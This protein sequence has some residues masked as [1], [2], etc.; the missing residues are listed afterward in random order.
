MVLL[1]DDGLRLALPSTSPALVAYHLQVAWKRKLGQ[2]A[3]RGLGFSG[4][5][6]DPTAF[7]KIQKGSR[8]GQAF[9]LLRAFVTQG[10]WSTNRLCAVGYD[11]D[12]SCP[13]CGCE[14]DTLH[15]K[16]FEC[17]ATETLREAYFQAD[18]LRRVLDSE[19]APV[20]LQGFQLLPQRLHQ[21]PAGLGHEQYESWTLTGEPLESVLRGEVFTDGSC[22]KEGPVTWHRTGWAVCKIDERGQLLAWARGVVGR[23]LPQT[24][25]A[26]EHVATLA[27]ATA[28]GGHVTRV[29]SDYKGLEHVEE[30]QPHQLY[31]R[32]QIYSGARQQLIGKMPAGFRVFKVQGHANV[33]A[34]RTARERYEALGNDHAD[35]VAKS[36]AARLPQPSPTE[37]QAWYFQAEFLALYL[38]YVPR[39]LALW[40]SIRPSAGRRSLPKRNDATSGQAPSRGQAS[41]AADVLGPRRPSTAAQ[42]P[43]EEA[44]VEYEAPKT[45]DDAQPGAATGETSAVALGPIGAAVGRTEPAADADQRAQGSATAAGHSHHSKSQGHNLVSQSQSSSQQRAP[46]KEDAPTEGHDWVQIENKWACRSWSVSRATFPPRGKCPGLAPSLADLVRDPRG[47]TLQIAPYS[48]R[49]AVVIICSRCGHLAAS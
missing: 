5:Q 36:A 18:E 4:A 32:S 44:D 19:D 16:L 31:A 28:P 17:T 30:L 48:D 15:H 29:N 45:S 11:V 43:Q 7:Q 12:P 42:A 8:N 47:H 27:A 46:P 10:I 20:L 35:R 14:N 49:S 22:V 3:A 38:Q 23:Q 24:S 9:P 37:L 26:S 41:F 13:H 39:A 33:E 34:A 21:P 25:P 1:S 2:D 6:L 40:P